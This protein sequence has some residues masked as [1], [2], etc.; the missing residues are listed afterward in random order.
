MVMFIKLTFKD[1]DVKERRLYE[2]MSKNLKEIKEKINKVDFN[3]YCVDR[4]DEGFLMG[5]YD[6]RTGVYGE[7][8]VEGDDIYKKTI[9][10]RINGTKHWVNYLVM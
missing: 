4:Y 10:D 9:M 8:Y 6:L 2:E 3:V 5:D 1:N 7:I